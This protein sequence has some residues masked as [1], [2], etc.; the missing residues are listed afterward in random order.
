VCP[1]PALKSTRWHLA[2]EVKVQA[3]DLATKIGFRTRNLSLEE[4]ERLSDIERSYFHTLAR[5]ENMSWIQSQ[6]EEHGAGWLMVIDGRVIAHGKGLDDY[7]DET[8]IRRICDRTGKFPFVFINDLLVAVEEATTAWHQTVH[9]DDYYPTL[10]LRLIS[11]DR[12]SAIELVADFDTG[13]LGTFA[14]VERLVSGGIIQITLFD[15]PH[16]ATH[17]NRRYSYI[18]KHLP[19]Q[20]I[21]SA[22]RRHESLET[23]ICVRDWQAGPFVQINPSR[24]ALVGRHLPARLALRLS[25]DFVARRTELEARRRGKKT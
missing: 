8:E 3:V 24:E 21:G 6:L 25:L 9:P 7:P 16:M 1:E 5:E 12:A 11:L 2:G 18:L 13:A 4:Y 20:V 14:D 22:G 23:V 15:V 17:L 10:G 19:V